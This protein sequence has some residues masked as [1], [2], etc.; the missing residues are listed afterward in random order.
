MV[1]VAPNELCFT[2]PQALKDIY[3]ANSKLTKAPV[4]ESLGFRSTFTTIN[5]HDYRVKKKR[6]LPSF[7]P[8]FVSN[9]IEPIV[10][11]QVA[12]LMKCLR[13]RVDQPL[14]VLPWFRMLALGIVGKCSVTVKQVLRTVLNLFAGEGFAGKS[15]GGLETEKTPQLLH[16]ID[17]VFPGLWVWWM[18]P[19]LSNLLLYSPF[20]SIKSFL[21]APERFKKVWSLL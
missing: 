11:R 9:T 10:Q 6:I 5:Q 3:G 4:Y 2:S 20:T 18:F 16:D 1:R 21:R 19:I 14:D 15:F 8:V 7:S 17:N 12:Y 13:A